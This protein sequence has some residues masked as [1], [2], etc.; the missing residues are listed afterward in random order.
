MS[1]NFDS[2]TAKKLNNLYE[3]LDAKNRRKAVLDSLQLQ[4]GEE[5]LDIGTGLGHL[6]LEMAEITGKDSKITGIDLNE[7]MLELA[8]QK[9]K[10]YPWIEFNKENATNLTFSDESFDVAVSVQV[11]EYVPDI[12]KALSEMYRILKPG[13]RAVIVATDWKS[14]LWHSSDQKRMNKV[15]S[16]WEDHCAYSDLPRI[17]TQNL[18]KTGF[19]I[20]SHHVI[21]QFNPGL[22][23]DA[24]SFHILDFIKSFVQGKNGVTP[25]EADAWASD[26]YQL[27]KKDEY[28]F[29]LN[30]F[31]FLMSK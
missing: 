5:V 22:N 15:L 10:D 20:Q 7:P 13:G 2:N 14:I 31:L 23:A 4:A 21:S 1:I 24:Y 3:S 30:Q 8:H 29:C 26:L 9:C 19:N 27:D 18:K 12:N 17:L 28:F 25:E 6:A 11:Y 16:A